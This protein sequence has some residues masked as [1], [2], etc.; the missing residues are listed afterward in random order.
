M[1]DQQA[2]KLVQ[3]LSTST[4]QGKVPWRANATKDG[5]LAEVAGMTVEL[6]RLGVPIVGIAAPP[7]EMLARSFELEVR[8]DKGRPIANLRDDIPA[9]GLLGR[10][11]DDE[12]LYGLDA[13][14]NV[15][16]KIGDAE[17]EKL[18]RALRSP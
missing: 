17:I 12:R 11:I 5:F 6:R 7:Q 18:I 14:F 1:N 8:N 15:I 4:Q 10:I 16:D 2:R 3:T 13:L 9:V